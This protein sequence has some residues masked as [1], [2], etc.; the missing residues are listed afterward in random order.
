MR[1]GSNDQPAAHFQLANLEELRI[2]VR[3]FDEFVSHP[4]SP[5][6]KSSRLRR[7]I[8]EVET[9]AVR[10]PSLDENLVSLVKRHEGCRDLVLRISTKADPEKVRSMLP[11][12]AQAGALEAG[13][14]LHPPPNQPHSPG[15]TSRNIFPAPIFPLSPPNH[16]IRAAHDQGRIERGYGR[17]PGI[18]IGRNTRMSIVHVRP[19]KSQKISVPLGEIP[20]PFLPF[21]LLVE[22]LEVNP[23]A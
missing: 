13:G 8:V 23:E 12:A 20:L 17:R 11:K 9:G 22:S 21:G 10:W 19:L 18:R 5:S 16:L 7:V 4:F 3:G 14:I 2:G 1:H 6:V 15:T